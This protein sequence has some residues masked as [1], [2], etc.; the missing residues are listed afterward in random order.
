MESIIYFLHICTMR[1]SKK[2][3]YLDEHIRQIIWIKAH[4]YPWMSCKICKKDL[5]LRKLNKQL[6]W[7]GTKYFVKDGRAICDVCN[8]STVTIEKNRSISHRLTSIIQKYFLLC[9]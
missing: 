4:P 1:K 7:T 8:K 2:I 5:L 3:P 9:D 6:L